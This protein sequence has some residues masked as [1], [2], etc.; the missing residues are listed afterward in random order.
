MFSLSCLLRR[1]PLDPLLSLPPTFW[2]VPQTS[3]PGSMA[4]GL[5]PNSI[6]FPLQ[7]FSSSCISHLSGCYS[8]CPVTQDNNL[9]MILIFLPQ[10]F[11]CSPSL[12]HCKWVTK[13]CSV[14]SKI[15]LESILSTLTA[16]SLVN[17]FSSLA[18]TIAR[19]SSLTHSLVFPPS[20]NPLH[21]PQGRFWLSSPLHLSPTLLK[22][23][24]RSFIWPQSTHLV[25][26]LLDVIWWRDLFFLLQNLISTL[27]STLS[28]LC[29]L[30]YLQFMS[31]FSCEDSLYPHHPLP[32][33]LSSKKVRYSSRLSCDTSTM[34]SLNQFWSH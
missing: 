28:T 14:T 24:S 8:L 11:I 30:I 18:K 12:H 31:S 6:I 32:L 33:L 29:A 26:Y 2:Q 4:R 9:G 13:S 1:V 17:T 25:P 10:L 19:P 23:H 16:T 3:L 5:K 22:W 21:L 7:T 27:T 15:F 20:L 34:A